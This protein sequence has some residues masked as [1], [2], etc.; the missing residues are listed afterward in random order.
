MPCRRLSQEASLMG[1]R[2]RV[3]LLTNYREDQQRSMLRFADLLLSHLPED[4]VNLEEIHPKAHLRKLC[5]FDKWKKWTGYLDKYLLFPRS[6]T[7]RLQSKSNPIDVLHVVD[8]SNAVYLPKVQRITSLPKL[9]TCHDLIAIRT[10]HNEFPEAPRTSASGKRLQNWIHR[11]LPYADAY[12]CD[13]S[14]TKMDL[15][16]MV[17]SSI[18][19]SDIIHLGV[20]RNHSESLPAGKGEPLPFTPETTPYILHVGSAA[21][22]KN[23]RAVLRTFQTLCEQKLETLR[24]VMIGPEW[25]GD[26]IDRE[27]AIWLKKNREK[28]MVFPHVSENQLHH[29]YSHAQVF[30]FPSHIEGFGWPPMEAS[31]HGCPVIATRTGAIEEILDDSVCYIKPNQG[32]DILLTTEKILSN[33][34]KMSTSISVPSSSEC[35]NLYFQQYVKLLH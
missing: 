2:I 10:A 22:Y 6:L 16:R 9:L 23:R 19:H 4:E 21:W 29:L 1:V 28:V 34:K 30:L 5:P 12:A 26:E 11:S 35:A 13:S 27:T 17:P 33:R 7:R 18:N 20:D 14:H 24:L 15:N 25:Q 8:H 32:E 3:L 31:L